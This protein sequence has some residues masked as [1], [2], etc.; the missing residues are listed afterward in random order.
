MKR[1]NELKLASVSSL[2]ASALLKQTNYD[3]AIAVGMKTLID[4]KAT[5]MKTLFYNTSST[6]RKY[7]ER[8]AGAPKKLSL[9]E[10]LCLKEQ[11]LWQNSLTQ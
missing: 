5:D 7:L 9:L 4:V 6:E 2:K 1:H 10:S 3:L 11:Q 8:Q